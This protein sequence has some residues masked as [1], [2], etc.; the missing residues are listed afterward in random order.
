MCGIIVGEHIVWYCWRV[1][2]G[3]V[4]QCVV[5]GIVVGV[6]CTNVWYYWIV[7]CGIVYQCIAMC[8]IVAGYYCSL[9]IGQK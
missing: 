9:F 7:L 6:L 3:I 1:L 8:G 2:C 5:C 4:Y